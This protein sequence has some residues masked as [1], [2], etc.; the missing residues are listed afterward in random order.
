MVDLMETNQVRVR[1]Q[2][3]VLPKDEGVKKPFILVIDDDEGIRSSLNLILRD[4]Y[5][6]RLCANGMEGLREVNEDVNAVILDIKM[7][8]KDGFEVCEEIKAKYTDIPIIFYSAFDDLAESMGLRLKYKP[9]AF[10]EKS[11]QIADLLGLIEKAIKHQENTRRMA[12][13][14]RNLRSIRKE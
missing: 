9:F 14:Q 1:P 5:R 3:R 12:Q 6:V 13:V 4:R 2:K 11:G 7:P 10:F 8:G